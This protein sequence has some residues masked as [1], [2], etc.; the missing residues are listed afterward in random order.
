MPCMPSLSGMS[1]VRSSG[2]GVPHCHD[3]P[4]ALTAPNSA[5]SERAAANPPNTAA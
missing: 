5:M 4:S 1:S 3:R 2:S